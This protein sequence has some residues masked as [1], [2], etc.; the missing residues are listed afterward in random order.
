MHRLCRVLKLW[1]YK[2]GQTTSLPR[3]LSSRFKIFGILE[4]QETLLISAILHQF[5]TNVFDSSLLVQS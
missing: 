2:G 4:K 1:V 5:G 3:S